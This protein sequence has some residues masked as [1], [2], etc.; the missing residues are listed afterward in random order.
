MTGNGLFRKLPQR[1]PI[2]NDRGEKSVVCLPIAPIHVRWSTA[3][4][5]RA[6]P[7]AQPARKIRNLF[8]AYPPTHVLDGTVAEAYY[9]EREQRSR[10]DPEG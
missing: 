2:G 8:A 7:V 5:R 6:L 10:H 3:S 4:E 9:N 1:L